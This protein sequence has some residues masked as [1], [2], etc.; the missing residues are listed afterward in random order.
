MLTVRT[1]TTERTPT[2]TANAV[3]TIPASCNPETCRTRGSAYSRKSCVS[4]N[5]SYIAFPI[6]KAESAAMRACIPA[7]PDCD[8]FPLRSLGRVNLTS[9]LTHKT[10]PHAGGRAP[11]PPRL[12]RSR[13]SP[14]LSPPVSSAR[15]PTISCSTNGISLTR[16][17]RWRCSPPMTQTPTRKRRQCVVQAT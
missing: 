15:P 9:H 8:D 1:H 13:S 6:R 3:D 16:R 10:T 12:S 7:P 11:A 17:V 4:T 14:S 5:R 2:M